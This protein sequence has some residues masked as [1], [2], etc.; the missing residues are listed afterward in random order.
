M[1]VVEVGVE[2]DLLSGGSGGG[3]GSKTT[4]K[5]EMARLREEE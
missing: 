2:A 5:N 3:R 1:L 4:R